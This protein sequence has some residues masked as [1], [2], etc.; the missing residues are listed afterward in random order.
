MADVN[1][2]NARNKQKNFE[3]SFLIGRFLW[4]IDEKSSSP[5]PDPSQNLAEPE[6]C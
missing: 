4:T 5:D 1:V 3:N 6:H 2:R